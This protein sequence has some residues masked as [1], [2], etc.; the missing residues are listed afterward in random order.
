MNNLI[1]KYL[2]LWNNKDLSGL[3]S[4]FHRNIVIKDWENHSEGLEEALNANS[5]IFSDCPDIQAMVTDSSHNGNTAFL[6]LKIQIDKQ[7]FINVVDV[8][9][10]E[11]G[12]ITKIYAYRQ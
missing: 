8:V 1:I 3:S 4:I 7:Q 9:T 2:E 12:K 11:K 10:I 5:Q 6:Q